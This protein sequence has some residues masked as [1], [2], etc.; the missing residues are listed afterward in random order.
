MYVI[1][2]VIKGKSNNLKLVMK[3]KRK[4]LYRYLKKELL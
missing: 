3:K 4:T 1:K 2:Y